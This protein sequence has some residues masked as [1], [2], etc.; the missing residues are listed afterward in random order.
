VEASG[1]N[2]LSCRALGS[3]HPHPPLTNPHPHIR[4]STHHQTWMEHADEER[5]AQAARARATRALVAVLDKWA[6]SASASAP[7]GDAEAAAVLAAEWDA[8]PHASDSASSSLSSSS[9]SASGNDGGATDEVSDAQLSTARDQL[10]TLLLRVRELQRACDE[11]ER[12][13]RASDTA[14]LVRAKRVELGALREALRLPVPGSAAAASSSAASSSSAAAAA[15]EEDDEDDEV[16]F[17]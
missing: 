6:S 5:A 11:A 1:L 2:I 15:V 4:P 3:D 10:R 16:T 14:D 7:C 12:R 13:L 8:V 17:N 9:S